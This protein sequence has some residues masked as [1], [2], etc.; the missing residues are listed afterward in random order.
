MQSYYISAG[1]VL[2]ILTIMDDGLELALGVHAATNF[3]GA[4]FV[5]YEGAAIQTDSLFL[6]NELNPTFMLI[7]FV[8]VSIIFLI[9][10]KYKYGWSGF[11]K[12]LEKVEPQE[13]EII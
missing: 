4:V 7:G 1:L 9:V 3:T 10:C 6:T 11:N 2:G 12:I 5:G 13:P 8:I